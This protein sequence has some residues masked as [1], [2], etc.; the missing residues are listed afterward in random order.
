MAGAA[1]AAGFAATRLRGGSWINNHMNARAVD[2]N[3][4][5]H[6][7]NRNNN[8]G[9]RVVVV[10]R[11]TPPSLFNGHRLLGGCRIVPFY[12]GSAV[13]GIAGRARFT[14]RGEEIEKAQTSPVRTGEKH[15]RAYKQQ[16][17]SGRRRPPAH[18]PI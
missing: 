6:P 3:I 10:C 15:R 8:I 5:N 9:F 16:T 13:S 7:A 4:N 14:G 12:Q 1:Q 2:R 18:G 17:G 11:P